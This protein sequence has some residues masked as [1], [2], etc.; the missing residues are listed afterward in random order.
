[1]VK[2]P[3]ILNSYL[4]E[5][6]LASLEARAQLQA[7]LPQVRLVSVADREADVFDFFLKAQELG[8]HLLVRAARNR[9]VEHPEKYLWDYLETAP[10]AGHL[11]LEVPRRPGKAAR[12]ATL[13]VR[14]ISV[15]LLPPKHRRTDPTLQP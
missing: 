6:G 7:R 14:L 12:R 5:P 15:S 13:T 11:T 10:A 2:I 3:A 4:I 1:M 9:G 8:Q